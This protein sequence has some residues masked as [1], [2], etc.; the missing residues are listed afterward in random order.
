MHNN[1][2]TQME[3]RDSRGLVTT[4]GQKR[5]IESRN[6]DLVNN[7]NNI[8]DDNNATRNQVSILPQVVTGQRQ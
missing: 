8:S 6:F 1:N 2:N 4:L 7:K 3:D 5:Q